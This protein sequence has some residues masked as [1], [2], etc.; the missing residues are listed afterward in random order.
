MKVVFV[1]LTILSTLTLA[2][3]SKPTEPTKCSA[4]NQGR[5]QC[6]DE[7]LGFTTYTFWQAGQQRC[8]TVFFPPERKGEVLPVTILSH[9]YSQ[10][11]LSGTQ[12]DS[13][14]KS[15]N[16]AAARYG[17]AK[18]G[19]STPNKNWEFGNDNVVNDDKPRPC[20]DEDSRD[21]AYVRKIMQWVETNAD[22]DE[23]RMW[24]WGFSQNSMFS[25]Y[26]GYC[27]PD[28]IVGVYQAGSGL[29]LPPNP[30][31]TPGCEGHVKA[32]VFKQ[33]KAEGM[34]CGKCFKTNPSIESQY[35]PIY[36]CYNPT[37]PMVH[38]IEEYTNDGIS[39]DKNTGAST[40]R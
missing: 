38:C 40:A 2:Q 13:P 24:A 14:K 15:A 9:C 25:A 37:G 30:P 29:S 39:T 31:R 12:S 16:Q 26:I 1:F 7:D 34:N 21:I 32:S 5:C 33:C 18:I 22:L 28:N 3:D 23:T 36:P 17:Y 27:F 11:R 35:W 8:F 10:D 6:G 4:D 20:A 19:I